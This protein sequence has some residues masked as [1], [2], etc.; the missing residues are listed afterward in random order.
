VREKIAGAVIQNLNSDKE[1]IKW[2]DRL[3]IDA[4]Q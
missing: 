1:R 2:G 3:K 4:H